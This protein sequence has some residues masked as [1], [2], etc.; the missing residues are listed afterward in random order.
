[1]PGPKPKPIALRLLQGET[2]PSRVGMPEPK[3]R[4]LL[5]DAPRYLGKQARARWRELL[6]ELD[7]CGVL[8]R[9]DG[10]ILAGYC[11][12]YEQVCILTAKLEKTGRTYQVGTNGAWAAFPEVAMLSRA[13]DDIRK[14]GAELGIGAASRS[15]IEVKKQD[16]SHEDPTAKAISVAAARK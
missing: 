4:P 16:D 5:P 2:R 15:K 11:Q 8:T 3:P 14:F 9:I 6:P 13:W 10:E 7:Y 12:A 1:M